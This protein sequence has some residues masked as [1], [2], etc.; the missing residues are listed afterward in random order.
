MKVTKEQ[1]SDFYEHIVLDIVREQ[2]K[3]RF[4]KLWL[5]KDWSGRLK[6]KHK[7]EINVNI[8]GEE[9][10]GSFCA[11]QYKCYDHE[12]ASSA[13]IDA[14]QFLKNQV[15][16]NETQWSSRLFVMIT[17]ATELERSLIKLEKTYGICL[18]K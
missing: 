14:D 16:K 10:N 18:I 2:T 7:E 17:G 11:I 6:K 12:S 1:S 15:F 5:Y 3:Q 4:K 9:H 13:D 8:V